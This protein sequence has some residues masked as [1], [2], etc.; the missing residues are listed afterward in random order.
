MGKAL[1]YIYV[2]RAM[3]HASYAAQV[4]K[5]AIYLSG[6]ILLAHVWVQTFKQNDVITK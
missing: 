1:I 5:R 4:G 3:S 6:K 2:L